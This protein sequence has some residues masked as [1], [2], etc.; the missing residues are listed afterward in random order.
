MNHRLFRPFRAGIGFGRANPGALPRAG[1][2]RAVGALGSCKASQVWGRL[3]GPLVDGDGTPFL[4]SSDNV[5]GMF[6]LMAPRLCVSAGG[7][8]SVVSCGQ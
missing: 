1:V 2:C 4:E 7:S 3:V 6:F 8:S 5:G